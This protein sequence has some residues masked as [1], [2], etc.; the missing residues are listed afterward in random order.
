MAAG[1][2][3]PIDHDARYGDVEIAPSPIVDACAAMGERLAR[4]CAE[5][6][7]VLLATG[8]PI[9]LALLYHAIDGLLAARGARGA[10]AR[11]GDQLARR[12]ISRMTG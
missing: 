7:R 4:A 6:E 10:H 12:V 3:S 8:H 2:G 11:P 5:G 1:A 9:G